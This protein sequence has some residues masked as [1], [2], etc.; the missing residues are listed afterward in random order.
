VELRRREL[1][2]AGAGFALGAALAGC[3][4]GRGL[5]GDANR[6]YEAEIDGDLV[7]FNW[8]Y[9]I[10][11]KLLRAFED[12]YDVKVLEANFDSMPAMMAK[13]RSG[14]AYDLIFP[15]A[16]FTQRLVQSGGLLQIDRDKIRNADN[17]ISFFDNPWYDPGS[18]HTL[19]YALYVTGIG[20]RTDEISGM[21]GSWTDLADV[22]SGGRTYVLDDYQEAIGMANLVNDFDLNTVVEAEL[23]ESADYLIGLKD[24]LRGFSSDT[25]TNMSSGNALIQHM[26]NGDLVNVQNRVDNPEDY[27]FQKCSEGLPVGSDCFAIPVNAEHPGTAVKFIDFMLEPENAAQNVRYVGYPMPN[28]GAEEAFDE[29]VKDNPTLEVTTDDLENGDE[30]ANLDEQGRLLWDRTWTEVKAS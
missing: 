25:I 21:T 5:S 3:G 19:P 27:A 30:F 4:I 10:D 24:S 1:L 20:Y 28:R 15:S 22:D 11:P 16:E 17:V 12:R 9:Y 23:Q 14:N 18:A 2:R 6:A 7:Y 13:L 29:I 26:W 8:G